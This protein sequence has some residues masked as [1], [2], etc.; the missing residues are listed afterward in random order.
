M[1]KRILEWLLF[2]NKSNRII[3]LTVK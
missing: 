1:K 2:F 3:L